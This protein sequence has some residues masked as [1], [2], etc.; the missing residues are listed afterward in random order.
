MKRAAVSI[1]V[2]ILAILAM[3]QFAA[4]ITVFYDYENDKYSTYLTKYLGTQTFAS[5][6]DTG[7]A[8]TATMGAGVNTLNDPIQSQTGSRPVLY[9]FK[10]GKSIVPLG[11]T[12]FR[13]FAYNVKDKNMKRMY[14][15]TTFGSRI[16]LDVTDRTVLSF[17]GETVGKLVTPLPEIPDLKKII[18]SSFRTI[19]IRY[20]TGTGQMGYGSVVETY[21]GKYVVMIRTDCFV[22]FEKNGG[23]IRFTKLGKTVTDPDQSAGNEES[24]QIPECSASKITQGWKDLAV[25]FDEYEKGGYS[26]ATLG[27]KPS[28]QKKTCVPKLMAMQITGDESSAGGTVK[29]FD[30][31]TRKETTR[32]PQN[33]LAA[34]GFVPS[35]PSTTQRVAKTRTSSR[36]S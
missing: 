8:L 3:S 5:E 12:G 6:M 9:A 25:K 27:C 20:D 34:L 14:S 35:A 26:V 22:A 23:A 32:S 16:P 31:T 10:T 1:F 4:A 19:E 13:V 21:K 33:F 24:K 18:E 36:I 30:P 17:R 2:L 28:G 29:Y 11:A 7:R 15:G